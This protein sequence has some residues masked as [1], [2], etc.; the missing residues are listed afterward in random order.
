MKSLYYLVFLALLP[1]ML[2]KAFAAG[3]EI[4]QKRW[5]VLLVTV[6]CMRPDHMSVYGYER[7][8]TP[9]LAKFAEESLV[10]ENAFATSGWTSPGV[11]S[12]LTGYYP[13]VHGQNGRHSYYDKELTAPL[14]IL[15]EE[16][17]EIW[18]EN[19]SGPNYKDIGFQKSLRN[20]RVKGKPKLETFIEIMHSRKLRGDGVP[21]FAWAHL[22][23]T[24][25]PY[26]PSNT[27]T[28][29]WGGAVPSS[30]G[31]EAVKNY[32][33]IFRQQDVDVKYRHAGRVEFT[34]QDIPAIRSLYDGEMADVDER[35]GHLFQR[36]KQTGLLDRTV[37]VITADHGEELLEHGWIGHAS[38]SY[39]GKLYDE[40]IRIPLIIRLPDQ[41][42]TGRFDDLI[43]GVDVMPT[44]FELIGVSIDRVDPPMQGL[45]FLPAVRGE[46]DFSRKFVFSQ[47]TLKGWT[48]PIEEMRRRVLSVRTKTRKLIWVPTRNGYRVEGYHL[49]EDPQELNDIYESRK[50]E[51]ADLQRARHEWS[52]ENRQVAASLVQAAA[53]RRVANLVEALR[54]ADLLEA[55][56]NWESI[57]MLNRTWGMEVD[58]FFDHEP[59]RSSWRR[60]KNI[61]SKLIATALECNAEGGEIREI[62]NAGVQ[63]AGNW[64]CHN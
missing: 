39:D 52:Q 21:F 45:S 15:S 63:D 20:I 27:N 30:P 53:E 44:V 24:H 59:Y 35:L 10:F 22:T 46:R 14:R 2:G 57:A 58:P 25:L 61:A 54:H 64:K 38:T 8:T 4:E 12:L 40:I 55:V 28:V 36:L 1:I 62:D 6:D 60:T 3:T 5:N 43:Q 13:P 18:G 42:I 31:I 47:T 19:N 41:S 7:E 33:M 34:D 23:E 9:Q 11:V 29:R 49:G 32:Q 16:G 37:V 56:R 17:Y 51:F 50:S 48:T 26:N